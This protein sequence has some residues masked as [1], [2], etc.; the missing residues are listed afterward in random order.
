MAPPLQVTPHLSLDELYDRYRRNQDGTAK[1]HWQIL[2][3]K[4]Q[5]HK[6][7]Q[8]AEFTGY[9][10]DW[11]RR[12]VRRYNAEG[13][14]S[15]GDRRSENGRAPMLDETHQEH[16]LGALME[17]PE[18]GGLWNSTK[19]AKWMSEQMG[20]PVWPQRG[21]DYLHRFGMT[22]KGPRP[23]HVEADEQ[24]QEEFKKKFLPR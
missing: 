24:A 11:I 8:I 4:A 15:V 7:Q 13:P 5:G 9:Q 2:W 21:W 19:V 16:L 1:I 10:P 23:R 22:S 3:L 20:R 12:I 6:T 17:P 14:S 18:D